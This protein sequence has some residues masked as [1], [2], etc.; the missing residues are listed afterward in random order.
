MPERIPVIVNPAARSRRAS[1]VVAQLQALDPAPE[2][3]FTSHPGHATEIA[4]RLASEGRELVVAAGGDGTVN[5][6]LQGLCKVN[7]ARADVNSHTALG[8]LPAGTMNVFAL[9]LGYRSHKELI[10]PWRIMAGG[11]RR[12]VDLWKANEKYFVQLAGIGLDAEIIRHT[13]SEAKNRFGPLSYL[14]SALKVIHGPSPVLSVSMEGRPDLYGSLVLVGNGRNYGGRFRMFRYAEHSDLLDVLI[15]REPI[16]LWN[17]LQ[18]LRGTLFGGY[19]RKEDI[20]YLQ[21]SRFTVT[22]D[23]DIAFE[24]DGELAGRAPVTFSKAP[25]PLRV[26]AEMTQ[27]VRYDSPAR[28]RLVH[29]GLGDYFLPPLRGA[30]LPALKGFFVAKAG[31][32]PTLLRSP[33]RLRVSWRSVMPPVRLGEGPRPQRCARAC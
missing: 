15:F 32:L 17:G 7:A 12:Q 3:H 16:N 23:C 4:E 19:R 21:L 26:A 30:L 33:K 20:D 31:L 18:L 6:V 29:L 9:E 5:E 24:L 14:W 8:T 27:L 11:A 1:L 10:N 28:T 13:S 2:L 25:F 22:S